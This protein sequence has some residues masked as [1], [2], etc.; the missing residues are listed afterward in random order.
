MIVMTAKEY[1]ERYALAVLDVLFNNHSS[2]QYK[3][4]LKNLQQ[5]IWN[6]KFI[7]HEGNKDFGFDQNPEDDVQSELGEVTEKSDYP[8]EIDYYLTEALVKRL[9]MWM[10]LETKA[11]V[12][13]KED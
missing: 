4:A 9:M 12:G 3:E 11:Q 1:A 2:E 13:E 10:K 8:S 6:N 7:Q 5:V